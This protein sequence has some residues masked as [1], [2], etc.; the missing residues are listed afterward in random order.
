MSDKPKD[1]MHQEE[2][3]DDLENWLLERLGANHIGAVSLV[4]SVDG[5]EPASL[6]RVDDASKLAGMIN[7][8]S[9][10]IYL[11]TRKQPD[12]EAQHVSDVDES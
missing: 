4:L 3:V 6:I 11:L 12:Q 8:S 2:F 5:E 10:H 9:R 7:H 1:I